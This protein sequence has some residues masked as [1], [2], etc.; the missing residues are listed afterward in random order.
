[1]TERRA[2]TR[3]G[4]TVPGWLVTPDGNELPTQLQD[5]SLH[6]ALLSVTEPWLAVTDT[7]LQL[8]LSL[9]GED[10]VIIMQ[11][12]QRYHKD[13]SI[14]IE[15]EQLDIES[16]SQ[17]RRL[18]ELNLGDEALLL[19]QFE[20]LLDTEK[21]GLKKLDVVDL[22]NFHDDVERVAR[23]FLVIPYSIPEQCCATYFPETNVLVPIKSVSDKSNTPTSKSVA[24]E[25]RKAE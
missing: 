7:P 24:I 13:G 17:L 20:E 4:F 5:I 11:A 18:M 21:R 12:R 23:K 2:F 10:Q 14:G 3:I 22:F 16:A 8:R 6:G 25:V 1:M 15:C 9:D 19:R